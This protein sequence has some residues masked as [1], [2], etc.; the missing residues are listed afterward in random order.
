MNNYLWLYWCRHLSFE[1]WNYECGLVE[2]RSSLFQPFAESPFLGFRGIVARAGFEY[3]VTVAAEM[4]FYPKVHPWVFV[5][6]VI[7]ASNA[8]GNLC[9]DVGWNP[10]S[11][12]AEVI[13][14]VIT[15]IEHIHRK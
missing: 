10:Q 3:K 14:A 7:S 9:L 8:N 1:R 12:F 6:P 2:E 15:H 5:T 13:G 11:T 4:E